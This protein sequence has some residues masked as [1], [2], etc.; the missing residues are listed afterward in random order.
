MTRHLLD[1]WEKRRRRARRYVTLARLQVLLALLITVPL[2]IYHSFSAEPGEEFI[3]LFAWAQV[4][5]MM[6]VFVWHAR[7]FQSE[8]Q[9]GQTRD[10]SRVL[11][12][13]LEK[14]IEEIADAL[15]LAV[16]DFEVHLAPRRFHANPSVVWVNRKHR[17][18]LPL[19]FLRL[20]ESEPVMA[21][22]M[23][24]HELAHIVQKDASLWKLFLIYSPVIRYVIVPFGI[25]TTIV[26]VIYFIHTY[27]A[28]SNLEGVDW[29]QASGYLNIMA[30]ALAQ[31]ALQNIGAP[32][33]FLYGIRTM[34]L[35]SEYL[36]DLAAAGTTSPKD[37][38][39]TLQVFSVR[40]ERQRSNTHPL[41]KQRIERLESLQTA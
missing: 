30:F 37:V 7:R 39:V 18:I 38:L 20:A 5:A 10:I 41:D 40:S 33:A 14:Q 26:G 35:K 1:Q 12:V 21:K 2:V 16:H 13:R 29:V 22:T 8:F 3:T 11:P 23:L 4:L 32:M 36:A 34:R 15:K 17:L 31:M 6:A 9:A 27:E 28:V 19:G 24:A 25:L